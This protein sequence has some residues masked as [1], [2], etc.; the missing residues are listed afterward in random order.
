VDPA[1]VADPL[2]LRHRHPQQDVRRAEAPRF[3]SSGGGA[4]E[5]GKQEL[6]LNSLRG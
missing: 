5:A 1:V 2:P 3:A 6:V 4:E